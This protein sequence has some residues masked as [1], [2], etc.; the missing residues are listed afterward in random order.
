M[1]SPEDS[2]QTITPDSLR[3]HKHSPYFF[4]NDSDR[5][6]IAR[7]F[8]TGGTMLS[9]GL[10]LMFDQYPTQED[11]CEVNGNH[12]ALTCRA[13]LKNLD[14]GREEMLDVLAACDKPEPAIKQFIAGRCL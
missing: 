12:H 6:L 7:H 10:P 3:F 8:F 14:E 4:S 9:W 1:N 13:W 5:D 11:R 2:H